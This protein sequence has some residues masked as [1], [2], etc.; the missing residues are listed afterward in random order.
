MGEHLGASK[1]GCNMM[2]ISHVSSRASHWWE[3]LKMQVQVHQVHQVHWVEE[4]GVEQP[5]P[6]RAPVAV[7]V[8]IPCSAR[9]RPMADVGGST[10]RDGSPPGG[11][12]A[13][14]GSDAP[15]TRVKSSR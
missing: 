10:T 5:P 15:A 11:S 7:G 3:R 4:V 12:F 2:T 1:F 14:P 13:A 6:V 8:A 9:D